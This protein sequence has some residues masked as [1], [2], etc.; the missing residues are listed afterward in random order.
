MAAMS[1]HFASLL[2]VLASVTRTSAEDWE[3]LDGPD[4][5][6]G[7]DYRYHHRGTGQEAYLNLDQDR[8]TISVDGD[9]L[10]DAEVPAETGLVKADPH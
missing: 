6:V 9:K 8:L 2:E 1:D 10:Y 5:G 4:S 7:V 3:S